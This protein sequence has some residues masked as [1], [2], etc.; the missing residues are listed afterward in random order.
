VFLSGFY[1]ERKPFDAYVAKIWGGELPGAAWA[2]E[3]TDPTP[4]KRTRNP[5]VAHKNVEKYGG[6]VSVYPA[7][8][9]ASLLASPGPLP[10]ATQGRFN[11]PNI[12]Y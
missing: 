1:I 9:F 10:L 4:R 11:S 8:S 6:E 7:L 12:R 3:N 5:S 2:Q